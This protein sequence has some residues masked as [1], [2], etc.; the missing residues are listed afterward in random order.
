MKSNEAKHIKIR[1]ARN[2]SAYL[3]GQEL[4]GN[5]HGEFFEVI[6]TFSILF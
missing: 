6:V 2:D 1:Y 3:L 4:T 5:K